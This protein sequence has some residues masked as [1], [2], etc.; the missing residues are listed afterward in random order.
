MMK[1]QEVMSGWH[2]TIKLSKKS[3]EVSVL[4]GRG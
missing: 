1:R 2:V 4:Q 3:G